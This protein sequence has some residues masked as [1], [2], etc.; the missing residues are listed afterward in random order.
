M[1]M[2]NQSIHPTAD[3]SRKLAEKGQISNSQ[4]RMLESNLPR[5]YQIYLEEKFQILKNEFQKISE[6][7]DEVITLSELEDF[8][9]SYFNR[10]KYL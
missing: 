2:R 5:D 7:S 3:A 8:V 9:E 10:V 6:S 1:E 4:G